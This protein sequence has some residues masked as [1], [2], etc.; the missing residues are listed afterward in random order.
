[1]SKRLGLFLGYGAALVVAGAAFVGCD[2]FGPGDHKIYRIAV[3]NQELSKGCY[4]VAVPAD[5]KSDSTT[6]RDS[7][8]IILY[9]GPEDK[10]FLDLGSVSVEGTADGDDYSFEG[11]DTDVQYMGV[12]DTDP[13]VTATTALTVTMT[14]DG[15][16]VTGKADTKTSYKCSGAGCGALP[17]SCTVSVE[18]VGTEVEDINFE[19]N[20]DDPGGVAPGPVVGGVGGNGGG[21]GGTTTTTTSTTTSTT[22]TT[23]TTSTGAA[24]CAGFCGG[25]GSDGSCY[26]DS[27][28]VNNGD[29]CP[30]YA[31][32][33]G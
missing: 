5:L 32:F 20:V 13:K 1:M 31:T 27:T 18:F 16:S 12:N 2:S 30:D 17:A 10:Y 9:A 23:T 14:V 19:F 15:A 24:T 8:T 29:C 11:K 26:C 33:C 21:G 6:F 4:G 22:S 7:H 3:T 28:C 25:A